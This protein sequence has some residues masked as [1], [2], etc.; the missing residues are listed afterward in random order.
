MEER[1]KQGYKPLVVGIYGSPRKGGNT[2]IL[3]DT[4]LSSLAQGSV[5]IEKV[6]VRD[7]KMMGCIEC[8]RCDETGQCAVKDQMQQV[9]PLLDRGSVIIL[10][11]PIF[12]YGLSWQAKAL[13]DRAQALWA[14]R[15]LGLSTK[16]E[17]FLGGYLLAVGATKGKN[18]FLGVELVAKYFYD[19]LGLPYRGG[20]FYRNIEKKAEILEKKEVLEEAKE[21]GKR[22]LASLSG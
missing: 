2:D 22:I 8:G 7:L 11:S 13:V 17:G 3:L 12:F 4:V 6:Y 15:R 9:Y 20:L 16:R 18:L 21:F 5:E 14:R 10:S 19:A 1:S